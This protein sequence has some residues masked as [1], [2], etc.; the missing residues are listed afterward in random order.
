M[1][2]A[3]THK[4]DASSLAHRTYISYSCFFSISFHLISHPHVCVRIRL[5][6]RH[7]S[8]VHSDL[9]YLHNVCPRHCRIEQYKAQLAAE[10]LQSPGTRRDSSFEDEPCPEDELVEGGAI[11]QISQ[12]DGVR[13]GSRG[14]VGWRSRRGAGGVEGCR[15]TVVKLQ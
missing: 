6:S 15:K 10:S 3:F 1:D 7:R 9:N 4:L 11:S 14:V 2:T 5:I 13:R 8:S 12:G